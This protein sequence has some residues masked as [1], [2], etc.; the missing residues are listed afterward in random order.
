[1]LLYTVLGLVL[2]QDAK[3]SFTSDGDTNT[4]FKGSVLKYQE[5]GANI[6]AGV[7]KSGFFIKN[8]GYV[9]EQYK[10]GKFWS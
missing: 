1:M 4:L 5:N 9:T 7:D 10:V 6:E 2:G 3:V 8:Q